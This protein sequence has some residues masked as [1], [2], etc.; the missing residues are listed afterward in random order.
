MPTTRRQ[1]GRHRRLP[2]DTAIHDWVHCKITNDE[3]NEVYDNV[4][5]E[6]GITDKSHTMGAQAF[7]IWKRDGE[8]LLKRAGFTG[9]RRCPPPFCAVIDYGAIPHNLRAMLGAFGEPGKVD[10]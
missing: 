8:A 7:E 6:F 3:L 2:T 1:R 4:F 5:T 9:I 10:G